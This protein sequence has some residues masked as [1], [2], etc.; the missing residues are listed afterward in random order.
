MIDPIKNIL[1]QAA[2]KQSLE[3]DLLQRLANRNRLSD[4]DVEGV[5]ERLRDKLPSATRSFL[6]DTRDLLATEQDNLGA[7]RRI[8]QREDREGQE[9]VAELF[10][11]ELEQKAPKQELQRL[12]PAVNQENLFQRLANFT[13]TMSPFEE[14]L[15]SVNLKRR[16]PDTM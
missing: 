10:A 11:R 13:R 3:T 12:A 4:R 5:G 14:K 6:P 2:V 9:Q 16:L 15:A 1:A 8:G 7:R